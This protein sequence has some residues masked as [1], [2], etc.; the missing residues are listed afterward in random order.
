MMR[1]CRPRLSSSSFKPYLRLHPRYSLQHHGPHKEYFQNPTSYPPPSQAFASPGDPLASIE[2]PIHRRLLR[3]LLWATLFC[4]LGAATGVALKTTRRLGKPTQ[5]SELDTLYMS[6]IAE[7]FARD[8]LV[9]LLEKDPEWQNCQTAP[10]PKSEPY[11]FVRHADTYS[12]TVLGGSQ[13]FQ[14]K[15]YVNNAKL[16]LCFV[17]HVGEG[18]EWEPGVAHAGGLASFMED[19]LDWLGGIFPKGMDPIHSPPPSFATTTLHT[20]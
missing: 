2:R 17:V 8:P 11:P 15:C 3:S 6:V 13:G 14:T 4:T 16:M 19:S 12:L 1:P 18:L 7:R 9:Q 5:G 10:N 20:N